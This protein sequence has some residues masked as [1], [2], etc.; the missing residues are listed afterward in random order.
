VAS[1]TGGYGEGN[2]SFGR[3]G[4]H[5]ERD[6]TYVAS[7]GVILVCAKRTKNWKYEAR[8]RNQEWNAKTDS[9]CQREKDEVDAN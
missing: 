6:S 9:N 7:G 5:G 8:S 3:G 4:F 1:F 2:H